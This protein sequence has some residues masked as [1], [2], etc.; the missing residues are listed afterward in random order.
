MTSYSLPFNRLLTLN[1]AG[2]PQFLTHISPT[3]AT[4]SYTTS[5]LSINSQNIIWTHSSPAY[6]FMHTYMGMWIWSIYGSQITACIDTSTTTI[7]LPKRLSLTLE[8][9][10]IR[11]TSHSSIKPARASATNHAGISE[12]QFGTQIW[13][14]AD[15]FSY[16]NVTYTRS[17][18][19]CITTSLFQHHLLI[20]PKI[21]NTKATQICLKPTSNVPLFT[22]P[23]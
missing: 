2:L 11:N 14:P 7:T 3:R 9:V 22:Q 20:P 6:L 18:I 21:K 16:P 23:S 10:A 5:S 15:S 12:N 8:F 4:L 17:G 1:G 13:R 19:N